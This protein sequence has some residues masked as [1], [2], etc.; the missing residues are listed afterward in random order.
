VTQPEGLMPDCLILLAFSAQL[1]RLR[2][3]VFRWGPRREP[4]ASSYTQTRL[5]IVFRWDNLSGCR[6]NDGWQMRWHGSEWQRPWMIPGNSVAV[7]VAVAVAAAARRM[8]RVRTRALVH[9]EQRVRMQ[10]P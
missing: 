10:S 8:W 3:I 9:Y 1:E 6:D 7:A 5:C 2:G 4:G